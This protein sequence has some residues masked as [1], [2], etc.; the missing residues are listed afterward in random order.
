MQQQQGSAHLWVGTGSEYGI[1]QITNV[2]LPSVY[3]V[4]IF[5]KE[6]VFEKKKIK[7]AKQLECS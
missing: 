1:R 6:F 3:F 5:L 7:H 2:F 4:Q